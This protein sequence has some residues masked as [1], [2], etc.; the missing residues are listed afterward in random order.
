MR[1]DRRPGGQRIRGKATI[2]LWISVPY[3][4][5]VPVNYQCIDCPS[6]GVNKAVE[7]ASI[8]LCLQRPPAA[9]LTKQNLHNSFVISTMDQIYHNEGLRGTP[10]ELPMCVPENPPSLGFSSLGIPTDNMYQ[11]NWGTSKVSTPSLEP[12]N[13]GSSTSPASTQYMADLLPIRQLYST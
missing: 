6:L 11:Q 2:V 8:V 4:S 13:D 7:A 3:R 5:E 12:I 10:R 9:P 1:C